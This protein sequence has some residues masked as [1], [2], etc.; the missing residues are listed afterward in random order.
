MSAVMEQD[1]RRAT[2]QD[3]EPPRHAALDMARR[4]R[5]LALL[6]RWA[7]E[8]L[9]AGTRAA[10]DAA[11]WARGVL[12]HT[13]MAD[14]ESHAA[15]SLLLRLRSRLLADG[16]EPVRPAN[17]ARPSPRV[18]QLIGCDRLEV[19]ESALA[20]LPL[21]Q[22]E[23]VILRIEFGLDYDAI[24]EEAELSPALARTETVNALAALIDAIA[25]RQRA[26]AA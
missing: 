20:A 17:G 26:R 7:Q 16:A 8:R 5:Y 9:P 13:A 15:G 24:A 21:R 14:T 18:E 25:F 22:R 19:W 23:L 11:E 3:V 12:I 4:C 6:R 1:P 10:H 2:R